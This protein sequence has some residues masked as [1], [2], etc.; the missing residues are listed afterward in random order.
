MDY[1]KH[2]FIIPIYRI[3][4]E[5]F[6]KV[7]E[8]TLDGLAN[9]NKFKKLFEDWENKKLEYK[10]RMSKYLYYL[11]QFNEVVGW[12]GIFKLSTQ[13]RGE[14]YY[15]Y[16]GRIFQNSRIKIQW[17]GKLFELNVT[18]DESNNEIFEMVKSEIEMEVKNTK[19]LK[20]RYVDLS[21]FERFG[22]YFDW[23]AFM[24]NEK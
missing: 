12:I 2:I 22:K 17:V 13:I 24:L 8:N 6:Y 3:S 5:K 11:W 21:S 20:K 15:K 10:N 1:D 16:P 14:I 18:G 23:N 9:P 4:E 19:I 7:I